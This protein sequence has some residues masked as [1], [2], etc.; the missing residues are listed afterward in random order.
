MAKGAI[1]TITTTADAESVGS[2][3]RV[4]GVATAVRQLGKI[5]FVVIRDAFS[6]IQVI[7]TGELQRVLINEPPPFYVTVSGIVKQRPA[8]DIRS[9]SVNGSIEIEAVALQ[10]HGQGGRP[11]SYQL[12]GLLQFIIFLQLRGFLDVNTLGKTFI[13]SNSDLMSSVDNLDS[14]KHLTR[15]LGPCRW[16]LLTN[17]YLYFGLSPGFVVDLKDWL[18]AVERP[19]KSIAK[20]MLERVCWKE[21]YAKAP[22]T[23]AP[24]AYGTI[25]LSSGRGNISHIKGSEYLRSCHSIVHLSDELVT[26]AAKCLK[27]DNTAI[28]TQEERFARGEALLQAI[29]ASEGRRSKVIVL[30]D[31]IEFDLQAQHTEKMLALFP[32]LEKRLMHSDCAQQFEI[33]W[34]ILGHDHVKAVFSSLEAVELLS[35]CIQAGMFSDYNILRYLSP[36]TLKSICRL[37]RNF[38]RQESI[39]LVDKMFSSNPSVSASACY[40]MEELDKSDLDWRRCTVVAK[41]GVISQIAFTAAALD[42]SP[43]EDIMSWRNDIAFRLRHLFRNDPVDEVACWLAV[44]ALAERF[45][46]V[47]HVMKECGSIDLIFDLVHLTFGNGLVAYDEGAQMY[48]EVSD[49]TKHWALAGIDFGGER[50]DFAEQ[51]FEL[52]H[53]WLYPSKNRPAILA[54]S[55]SGICSA[56][57]MRLFNRRD[58]FQ[59][60]LVEPIGLFAAGTVQMYS[61]LDEEERVIWVVRG[62]NPSERVEI[63][64]VGF[65]IELLDTV[66]SLACYNGVSALVCAE[67]AGLFNADSSRVSIRAVLRR[68]MTKKIR[69]KEPLHIFDYHDRPISIEFGWQVWP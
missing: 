54:K 30:R 18:D 58:H 49:C 15:L 62:L 16:Y 60:T 33:L 48:S 35:A 1:G 46:W 31:L 51:R 12:D 56:R 47:E 24:I 5:S 10:I 22:A 17:E 57:N 55:C 36:S 13:P 61:L 7:V 53:F 41:R 2:L 27:F 19:E 45:P 8:G 28:Q 29:S 39:E 42:L 11:L 40:L 69:F 6:E 50:W 64:P 38:T 65:T 25:L 3:T 26:T 4:V 59:F 14:A 32:S 66:A 34:S 63:E 68:S 9:G 43:A 23:H 20:E 52:T 21:E 44:K 37:T 67:G